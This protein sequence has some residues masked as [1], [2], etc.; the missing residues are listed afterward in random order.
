M[1]T[2]ELNAKHFELLRLAK[3]RGLDY[4]VKRI[5]EGVYTVPSFT[6]HKSGILWVVAFP[7]TSMPALTCSCPA[8]GYCTHIA[9]A[10][11]RHFISEAS[12]TDYGRYSGELIA[13]RGA[14]RHRILSGQLSKNDRTYLRYCE[15][16]YSAKLAK[17]AVKVPP[18]VERIVREGRRTRTLTTCGPFVI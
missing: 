2:D 10:V 13:D 9:A 1:Q 14:L 4:R 7:T 12:P 8:K 5:G 18:V 16:F 15:R 6:Q 17:A 11:D 3:L